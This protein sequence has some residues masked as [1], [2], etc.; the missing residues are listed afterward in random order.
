M[1]KI[2]EIFGFGIWNYVPT[3][4]NPAD[5]ATRGI[6]SEEFLNVSLWKYGPQFLEEDSFCN[7]PIPHEETNNVLK[8]FVDFKL[9]RNPIN[10]NLIS[11]QEQRES[12]NWAL[13]THQHFYFA[14]EIELSKEKNLLNKNRFSFLSSFLDSD[15][16]LHIGGR[17]SQVCISY[18][19]RHPAIVHGSNFVKF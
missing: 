8:R 3:E 17:L 7:F 15:E 11:L 1:K 9:I 13:R 4:S 5:L 2:R 6:S 16:I 18:Q 14:E 12:A 19:S 10:K